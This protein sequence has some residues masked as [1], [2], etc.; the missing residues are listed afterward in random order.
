MLNIKLTA[1]Q[2]EQMQHVTQILAYLFV[3][4]A[5]IVCLINLV[6]FIKEKLKHDKEVSS[7]L[8]MLTIIFSVISL[9]LGQLT[10][11]KMVITLLILTI[12]PQNWFMVHDIWKNFFKRKT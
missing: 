4:L 7:G 6:L 11:T 3:G 8:A 2:T 1:Q 12:D 5:T 10:K 9:F